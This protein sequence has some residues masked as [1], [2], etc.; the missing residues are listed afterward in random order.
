MK[1]KNIMKGR[2]TTNSTDGD[3]PVEEIP[4]DGFKR[5]R[6]KKAKKS[7]REPGFV[8][9][10]QPYPGD[11]DEEERIR[12]KKNRGL[13]QMSYLMV[14]LFLSMAGY[15]IYFN[16]KLRDDINN[17]QYNTKQAVYQEQ[18]IRGNIYSADGNALAKTEIAEDGTESRVYP[19]SNMFAHIVGYATNGKSGVESVNNYDLN[20]SH[21]SILDQI[22]EEKLDTKVQGDSI[23]LT[24]NSRLQ[25]VCYNALGDNKGAIV[26][27]EP[28]TGKILAMVS[29]P[30][31]DP[32]TIE[33][34]WDTL[35]NDESNSSLFNRA[36]QGQY[37]P[38]STFKILTAL[39]YIR[40]H[41]DDYQNFSYTCNGSI[42]REDVTITCY[43]GEVHGYE[44]LESSFVNSCN[45]AFAQI[46]MDIDNSSFKKLCED[47]MFNK[48]MPIDLP[49]SQSLFRLPENASYGE[50]M[51]TGIGQ[52]E[53][54]VSPLEMALVSAT[55]ANGGTMMN[56]YY[57]DRI[58]TY[59]G[60]VVKQ[61]KPSKYKE[62]MSAEEVEIISGFMEKVVTDGTARKISGEAYTAAGKTGSAEYGSKDSVHGTHSWFT[63]YLDT[64]NPK[65]AISVIIEDGGAGSASAVPAAKEVFD[66][67]WYQLQY[68]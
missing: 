40:E 29:K 65:L 4:V 22:R 64:E 39:E 50:D 24:L 60:D 42:S 43:E 55:V 68:E 17:N 34:D 37:P 44:D 6:Q 53:T 35:I 14:A 20:S 61:Y 52:G 2:S 38:G 15:L 62:L 31:F 21:A 63:G 8:D 45:G 13:V 3:I 48:D 16:V 36:I 66:S 30:D 25:E 9:G 56:P 10:G 59:D 5:K 12:R 41:P 54:V 33:Q 11:E 49:S 7:A 18:I 46:G 23:V 19:Y 1:M 32:N 58:E 28:D 47:F 57:I 26:V 51:M 67:W 27:L